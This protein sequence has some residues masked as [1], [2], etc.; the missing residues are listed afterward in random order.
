VAT[1]AV[2]LGAQDLPEQHPSVYTVTQ[3]LAKKTKAKSIT[4]KNAFL[5]IIA[6]LL[7]LNKVWL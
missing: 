2:V 6:S 1:L 3:P 7:P 5:T 4:D